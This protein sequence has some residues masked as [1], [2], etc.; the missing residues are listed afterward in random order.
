MLKLIGYWS[1]GPEFDESGRICLQSEKWIDPKLLV[2]ETY[3]VEYRPL[4]VEYLK[5][6]VELNHQ[7]GCSFCRFSD[8]P[9]VHEMGCCEKTDGV[10]V[11]P[12]GLW[13]YAERYRIRLP[14]EFLLHA[15][16]NNFRIPSGIGTGIGDLGYDLDFWDGWCKNQKAKSVKQQA[17]E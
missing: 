16:R 8:G 12:E 2:D 9:P 13:I 11:W 17:G 14:D 6:G 1:G 3:A 7:L 5:S 4:L 10:W 15:K